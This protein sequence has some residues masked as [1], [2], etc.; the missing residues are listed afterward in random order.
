MRSAGNQNPIHALGQFTAFAG[1]SYGVT[2]TAQDVHDAQNGDVVAMLGILGLVPGGALARF[3]AAI[4]K[5]SRLLSHVAKSALAMRR[6]GNSAKGLIWTH[7][8]VSPALVK[9]AERQGGEAVQRVDEYG[10]RLEENV[11]LNERNLPWRVTSTLFDEK[12]NRVVSGVFEGPLWPDHPINRLAGIDVG[13][14]SR[15]AVLLDQVPGEKRL[16]LEASPKRPEPNTLSL[17]HASHQGQPSP[18][19]SSEPLAPGISAISRALHPK[20]AY[21][22]TTILQAGTNSGSSSAEAAARLYGILLRFSDPKATLHGVTRPNSVRIVRS[23]TIPDR[24][25]IWMT[26]QETTTLFEILPRDIDDFATSL[27]R[28]VR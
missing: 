6:S 28:F 4:T 21:D 19:S 2:A 8:E 5:G 7:G 17:Q 11:E 23:S 14:R 20:L 22:L 13:Q 1:G 10:W 18:Y 24:L 25:E 26:S 12:G 15:A 9:A 27:Q 16:A 3:A